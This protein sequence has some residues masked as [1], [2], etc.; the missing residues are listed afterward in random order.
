MIVDYHC[1]VCSSN[2]FKL[3]DGHYAC[4]RCNRYITKEVM[5]DRIKFET[6]KPKIGK[7]PD[8]RNN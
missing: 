2:Q 6:N 1:G 5:E 7:R 8:E 4:V 3:D